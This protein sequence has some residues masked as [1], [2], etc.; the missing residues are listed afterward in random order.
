M[1]LLLDV[2]IVIDICQP[3]PAFSSLA[4]QAIAKCHAEGGRMWLYTGS[5]QTHS[6]PK[7]VFSWT[8]F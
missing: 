8:A 3:R 6:C 2:N 4:L 1:D 5:V 7:S